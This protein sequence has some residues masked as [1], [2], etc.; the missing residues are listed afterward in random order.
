MT[1]S[2]P[3]AL[4][5]AIRAFR[6]R[7]GFLAI[8]VSSLGIA[9]GLSTAVFAMI[10]A[11]RNPLVANNDVDRVVH[12]GARGNFGNGPRPSTL[13]LYQMVRPLPGFADMT[14]YQLHGFPAEGAQSGDM[15]D[16]HYVLPNYF[17][18]LG[19]TPAIG[20]MLV[21]DDFA[22]S[23]VAVVSNDVWRRQ[24]NDRGEIAEA[25]IRLGERQYAVVGVLPRYAQAADV[26]VPTTE[27][28]LLASKTFFM[29]ARIKPDR[30]VESMQPELAA[31]DARVAGVYGTGLRPFHLVLRSMRPDP[32]QLQDYHLA[33]IGAA[34]GIL[35]IGCANVA[36]LML[37]R[38]VTNRRDYA[39][40]LALGARP[41][42]LTRTVVAEVTVL[43]IAG[44]IAGMGVAALATHVLTVS[45]PENL[46]NLGLP[47]PQWSLRVFGVALLATGAAIA[48][49]A[50]GPAWY[51]A[52]TNP[53]EPLKESAGT[54]TG[55]SG[56]RFRYL[57]V[58]EIALSM[59]LLFGASLM[60]KSVRELVNYDFGFD[61][62][63]LISA[64]VMFPQPGN[65]KVILPPDQ[66]VRASAAALDR[67]RTM[68]GITHAAL[69]SSG[70]PE[71][72]A[73]ISDGTSQGEPAMFTTERWTY[74]IIGPDFFP[75]FGV[76][77]KAGRDFVDGDRAR[78]AVILSAGAARL[79]FP[80][81]DA[82]GRLVKLG[83]VRSARPWLPVVGVVRDLELGPRDRIGT[84]EPLPDVYASLPDSNPAWVQIV[85]R[86]AAE[87]QRVSVEVQ[88]L[89]R[90]IMPPGARV[91]SSRA[92]Q[93]FEATIRSAR[94]VGRLFV[95]LGVSSLVLAAAG[96]FSVLSYIV[97]QRMREFAVRI[98]L[99]AQRTDVVRLVLR[100]AM[101]MALAGTAIGA[102]FGMWTGFLIW[103]VLWGVYPVDAEALIIAEATLLL[104]TLAA[105]AVPAIR[106]TR[107]DPLEV[108]RAS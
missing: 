63:S 8:A 9:L 11:L 18:V 5:R 12:I 21:G 79:L 40:H 20:R 49:A 92:L 71:G 7:P 42:H 32:L 53:S 91:G 61:I 34:F 39:L 50:A 33:M 55:R 76:P 3:R 88:R 29:I 101:I 44:A 105:C 95:L 74:R 52:R 10:D 85:A 25:T 22:R 36:A 102:G 72:H 56:T 62:K 77:I 59:V 81:G 69:F 99:G 1:Q 30:S 37:A 31:I 23:D 83:D 93:R 51:A 35:L 65:A 106:A 17:G 104:A 38:G 48:L 84:D 46:N 108:M 90:D 60:A 98:A 87:P 73:V 41:G 94:Y 57:V 75:A 89:L 68:P 97:S 19:L 103:N 86:T 82:V 78:G 2:L 67:V 100:D 24:F 64:T 58:A 45:V 27:N 16:V 28:A 26:I 80:R 107:A 6:R 96:L 4:R 47:T 43:G 70:A 14:V 15:L 13:D 54:T 66:R